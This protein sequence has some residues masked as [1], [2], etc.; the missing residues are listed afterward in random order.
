M[1]EKD[2][3]LLHVTFLASKDPNIQIYTCGRNNT[4]NFSSYTAVF[5]LAGC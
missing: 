3:N 5:F 1:L 4:A 2:L